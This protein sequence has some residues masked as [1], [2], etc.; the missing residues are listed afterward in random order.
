MN[1][2]V[3]YNILQSSSEDIVF[4]INFLNG[5]Q[6]YFKFLASDAS[7]NINGGYLIWKSLLDNIKNDN[8]IYRIYIIDD[9]V[10]I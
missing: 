2:H 3:N 6:N 9:S 10:F 1:I 7:L 8:Q 4:A 5:I